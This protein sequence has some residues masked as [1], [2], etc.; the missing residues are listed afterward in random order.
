MKKIIVLVA[1]L[2]L[3]L[4]AVFFGLVPQLVESTL[5]RVRASPSSRVSPQARALH[6]D[7]EIVDLHADSLLW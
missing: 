5:N 6:G 7:L 2:L 1:G 3:V 4:L